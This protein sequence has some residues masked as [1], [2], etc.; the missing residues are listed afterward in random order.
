MRRLRVF[1]SV[2]LDGYYV[3]AHDDMGWARSD[4]PEVAALNDSNVEAPA[5]F[6]FGRKTY[7]LM[8]WF[9]PSKS[10]REAMPFV[11]ERM[12]AYEKLVVSRTLARVEWENSKLLKG[13]LVSE[14][15]RL[16]SE[17]GPDLLILGSG[18]LVAQLTEAGLI[19]FYRIAMIPVVL[20]EGRSQ[21]DGVTRRPIL[22]RTSVRPFA[23]GTVVM[24][25]EA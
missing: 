12:N 17:S 11:A 7:E 22:K 13:D 16:K 19:D 15:K 1:N 8:A 14:V 24:E 2:S 23:N 21:F 4:G 3:D 6:L 18:S 9:W 10:A 25:F 5:T 20:G